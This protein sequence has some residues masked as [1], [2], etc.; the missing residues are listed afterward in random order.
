MTALRLFVAIAGA[1]LLAG[2]A[3][4]PPPKPV[5]ADAPAI[6]VKAGDLL[7]E[8][9]ENAAA[10]ELKYK[11]KVLEVTGRVY[12]VQKAPGYGY[13]VNLGGDTEGKSEIDAAVEGSRP[14]VQ[15]VLG[16]EAQEEA[17]KLKPEDLVT[18]RGNCDGLRIAF[19]KLS[20]CAVV[21]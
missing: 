5:P 12:Q 6:K 15:C 17:A 7:K 3:D 19:V 13:V 16:H 10:A 21:K 2:C 8:F 9:R 18:I 4:P 1:A 14:G 20:R 11:D